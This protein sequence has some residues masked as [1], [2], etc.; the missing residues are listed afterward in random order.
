MVW[1]ISGLFCKLLNFEPRH[2]QIVSRILGVEYADI[3]TAIIGILEILLAILV[4]SGILP[5]LCALAQIILVLLMNVIEITITPDLL[6]FGRWNI[7]PAFL[8]VSMVYY[9]Q[10][11]WLKKI[12]TTHVSLS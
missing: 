8:F 6:L 9:Y 7:V 2:P 12:N 3:F 11:I 5:K 1:F 4:V 10:F